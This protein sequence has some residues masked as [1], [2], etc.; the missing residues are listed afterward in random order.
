MI[1]ETNERLDLFEA[2]FGGLERGSHQILMFGVYVVS[3]TIL[4]A[5]VATILSMVAKID[6][7]LTWPNAVVLAS[8]IVVIG[9]IAITFLRHLHPLLQKVT[10]TNESG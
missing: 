3:A 6:T 5:A 7:Q 1:E 2:R 9:C 8:A 10:G 4:G